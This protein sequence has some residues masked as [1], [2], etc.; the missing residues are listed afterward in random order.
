MRNLTRMLQ[1]V[2]HGK[3][4]RHT[5]RKIIVLKDRKSFNVCVR[6]LKKQGI[7]P[8]KQV[9]SAFM[10]CCHVHPHAKLAELMKHP[11]IRRIENDARVRAHAVGRGRCSSSTTRQRSSKRNHSTA[12]G[13]TASM[14]QI[15]WGVKRIQAPKAWP[16][17]RGKGIRIAIVDTGISP[18]PDLRISGGINTIRPGASYDDDNGHG[19][20]VAGTAAAL[21]RG[22][23]LYGTAPEAELYAVKAL[24]E[25]GEGYVSDIVEGVEWCIRNRMDVINLSLGLNGPSKM[26]RNTIRRAHRQGIVIVAS[27]GN[28]GKDAEAIDEPAIYPEVIAVAATDRLDCIASFSSRGLGIDV[29]APGAD[30]CS[31]SYKG[32]FA[33][34]SGTSMAAP[35][36]SGTAGLMLAA[37]PGMLPEQLRC[38]L[39]HTSQRL[40]GE[41]VTAQGAGLINTQKAVAYTAKAKHHADESANLVLPVAFTAG[42]PVKKKLT[43]SRQPAPSAAA[44]GL[45]GACRKAA[46]AVPSKQRSANLSRNSIQ[47]RLNK[48]RRR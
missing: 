1:A 30:I 39:V 16:E 11:S 23:L 21:G 37:C 28:N 4:A 47:H 26:L 7:V 12:K 17:T 22:H 33:E 15:P 29:A 8:L 41:P 38:A 34:D 32:G 10:L 20:H 18:H 48:P 13:Q 19:T 43:P 36:V 46:T 35:H 27:A 3:P 45:P 25:K 42:R 5:V 9:K 24:D 2:V 44:A 40:S 6:E 31:T 14:Q